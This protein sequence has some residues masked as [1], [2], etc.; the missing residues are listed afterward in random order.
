MID[1]TAILNVHNEG[2]LAGPSIMSFEAALAHAQVEHLSVESIVVLD[3]PDET[4]RS[5]FENLRNRFK[6]IFSDHGD[7]ALARNVGIAAAKGEYI[8]FLDGDDLWGNQWLA[9]AHDFCS[10]SPIA[11]IGHSEVNIIFGAERYLYWHLDSEN[12]SFDFDYLK[13]NNYWT[14]HVFAGREIFIEFPFMK[15]DLSVGFGYEDWYWNCQTLEAGIAHRPVPDTVHMIRRR[16]DSLMGR[17]IS[18]DTTE[19]PSKLPLYSWKPVERRNRY[20]T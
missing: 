14:A 6:L 4:T 15:G 7:P 19:F 1:I 8:A 12:P 10:R 16:T 9:K 20:Q 18:N 13:M 5:I 3:R 17:G 2:L 11:V